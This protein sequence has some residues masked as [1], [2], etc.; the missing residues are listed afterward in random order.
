LWKLKSG[1]AASQLS[2]A[3]PIPGNSL[4]DEINVALNLVYLWVRS[5]FNAEFHKAAFPGDMA[6]T[7][8]LR[9]RET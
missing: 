2:I 6:K 5:G 7:K 1:K 9:L 4:D 3:K 8:R